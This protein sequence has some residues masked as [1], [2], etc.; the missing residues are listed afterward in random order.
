MLNENNWPK[1]FWAETVNR[2]TYM[3]NHVILRPLTKKTPLELWHDRKLASFILGS[4]DVNI[5]NN[6][7]HC[8]N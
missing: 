2:A 1:Y 4:L 5:L 7:D 6:K 8:I 3:M